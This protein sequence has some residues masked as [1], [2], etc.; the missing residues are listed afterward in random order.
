MALWD[1]LLLHAICEL[2]LQLET[3]D[4]KNIR[5]SLSLFLSLPL[6]LFL[7]L[8]LLHTHTQTQPKRLE[9]PVRNGAEDVKRQFRGK[10]IVVAISTLLFKEI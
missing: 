3:T 4:V 6:S 2:L 5:D 1:S 9:I 7:S 8:S 10:E